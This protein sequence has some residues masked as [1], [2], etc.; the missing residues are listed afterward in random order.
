M[1]QVSRRQPVN[2]AIA[3]ILAGVSG[4]SFAQS[5]ERSA[6]SLTRGR[7]SEY[8]VTFQYNFGNAGGAN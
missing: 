7:P 3:A 1:S 2:V 5:L 4:A 6:L 8:G